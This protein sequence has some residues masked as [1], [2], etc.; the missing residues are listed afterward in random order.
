MISG[1]LGRAKSTV[2]N[3]KCTAYGPASLWPLARLY[4]VH[5]ER[6]G[7]RLRRQPLTG[8]FL[9]LCPLRGF[10]LR[11]LLKLPEDPFRTKESTLSVLERKR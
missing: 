9:S 8:G 2:T 7:K 6:K 5:A 4:R 10:R 1:S 3:L 11:Q